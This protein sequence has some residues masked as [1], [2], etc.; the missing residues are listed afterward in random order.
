MIIIGGQDYSPSGSGGY[1]RDPE[2]GERRKTK[3]KGL[4]WDKEK[5][6]WVIKEYDDRYYL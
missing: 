5:K 1:N 4:Y 2:L 3:H 6:E